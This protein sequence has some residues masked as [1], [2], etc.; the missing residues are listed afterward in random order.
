MQKSG[1]FLI[2]SFIFTS[3]ILEAQTS[4]FFPEVTPAGKGKVNTMI[5][6]M[7]YWQRMVRLGYVKA[8]LVV[9]VPAPVFTGIQIRTK[10]I[11]IQDSPDRC[12]TEGENTTQSENSLFINPE[13][14][15]ELLN[16]N[17]STDWDGITANVLFGANDRYSEDG[18]VSW[19][20]EIQGA[21]NVNQGDP[22]VVI[23][24]NG[25]WY[26]GKINND[27]GQSV[28]YSSDHG[29]NWHDVT[30]STV[31]VPGSDILDKNH[32]WA[33]N[34]V[35][36]P[37]QG[38]LYD[39]W[40][41]FVNGSPN[42]HQIELSRSEDHGLTWSPPV[43]ISLGVVPG[44]MCQGV[45]LQ[46]G[47]NGEV[48]SVF[49]IY[50][51][52]PADE[53][54]IG[55]TRSLNGGSVFMPA[56]RIFHNIKGIRTSGTSKDMRVNSYP[57]MAV[58]IS[59][60][61]HKGTIYVVWTNIGVPGVNTGTDID[62]YFMRSSDQGSTW[63]APS[64]VNQ[65][66]SG[67]GKQ[68]F[69]P[70]I[71][72]DPVTGNLCVIY[73]DDRNVSS[74]QCETWISYS[75]NSGDTWTDMKVSDV[76]FTP[77]PIPGLAYSYFGDYLGIT[78]RNM[79]A[80]PIWT[81]NRNGIALTYVSPVNLGPAPNQPYILYDSSSLASI[82]KTTRQNMNYGDSLY[83]SL[84]L[85]NIGDQPAN[86]V[87]AYLASDS[88]YITI[89]DSTEYYG[90]F[91]AGEVKTIQNGYSFKVSDT[92]PDGLRVKFNVR[93]ATADTAWYS[94]FRIEAHAPGL[95]I[96]RIVIQDSAH[97]NNNGQLDPGEGIDLRVTVLN[98]GDFNCP[99]T[100]IK[101]SS[102]S[103]YLTFIIDSVFI[104]TLLSLHNKT[105]VF[106]LDV[107]ADACLHSAA[108]LNF[109]AGSG[110]YRARKN[111]PETIGIIMEDW[112]TGDFTKFLWVSGGDAQWFI[113]TLPYEGVFS[114]R[115]GQ[116]LDSQFSW[117]QVDCISGAEDSISFYRKVS[118]E[119]GY[120]YLRFYID[121]IQQGQW[122][123]EEPWNRVAFPVSSGPHTLKWTYATDVYQLNGSNAAWLDNITFPSPPMPHVTAGKDTTIC[124]GQVL[125][126]NGTVSASDSLRWATFGDGIFSND[127]MP[128]PV[129]T[130]GTG[131][132]ISGSV[133][134]RLTAFGANGCSAACLLLTI[135]GEPV[136]HITVFPNDTLCG[137]QTA[138]LSA[139]PVP[140]GS[141][142]WTPGG[143]TTP[144][145]LVD[146]S[147]I[148]G[149]GVRWFRLRV[150]R[151]NTCS[152][153]DSVRVFFRDCTGISKNEAEM[154]WEVF[155]NPNNGSFILKITSPIPGHLSIRLQNLL[156]LVILEDKEL[157]VSGTY[158]KNFE[159]G[160]LVP[161]I[162]I[163]SLQNRKERQNLKIVVR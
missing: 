134:L 150:T 144:G 110:L 124:S 4:R 54:A 66:P 14:E 149:F 153:S 50:D 81:D 152:S 142:L 12:V 71:T 89:T 154:L 75:Y 159:I 8:N 2:V 109:T 143:F 99:G 32:L 34:S 48:Y 115:S 84:S 136:V 156:G 56:T 22:S 137:D 70:W 107:A 68:H 10:G 148:G 46:T 24:T 53:S 3:F 16:S 94:N 65:D 67:L 26:T 60:S 101:V 141:Y 105:V 30:V 160:Q 31:P 145:I 20:G 41:N 111:L 78:S 25:W 58:D 63:T 83:L 113:N 163:L 90:A 158:V 91:S 112:E 98:S 15:D 19:A 120:D 47:P 92:I 87:T 116:I 139:D 36:S 85:K 132:I 131:D 76:A 18:G 151:P 129:Y 21:G 51:A 102:S 27:F 59:N 11:Q 38:R 44:Y 138:H 49:A 43:N 79:M 62:I 133:K 86:D 104:D 147:S 61:P 40:T 77:V 140:D 155:P 35:T 126:L 5:D 55:F 9:P 97:G 69:L 37:F 157:D 123:G 1:I 80:Y 33:D 106:K 135:A 146:T 72:C 88:P 13:N 82:Q 100:W 114:A 64:K 103:D 17:N 162:Y 52:W 29:Q 42:F 119:T 74:A 118:S 128:D 6:N 125:H 96:S 121:G 93:A 57:S 73:Y 45:N 28:A 122:S 108:D 95:K 39:A 23:G 117:L 127:T 130:P 161:G 7:G